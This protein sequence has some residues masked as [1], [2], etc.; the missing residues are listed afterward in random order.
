MPQ[1][2]T[3]ASFEFD[4]LASTRR[5]RASLGFTRPQFA[6]LTGFSE[7]KIADIE[8][9]NK[10]A[11]STVRTVNEVGRLWNALAGLMDSDEIGPWLMR[12]CKALGDRRPLELV[13]HGEIDRIWQ[14]VYRLGAG[15][16]F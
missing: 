4:D 10:V 12:P 7:R 15:E 13:E 2:V 3:D 8:K 16:A 6:R 5:L 14:L 1:T 11:T 9:G